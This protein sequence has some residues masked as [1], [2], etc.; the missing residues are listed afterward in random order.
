[1]ALCKTI[2]AENGLEAPDAYHRVTEVQLV[3]KQHMTF[4]QVSHLGPPQEVPG[5]RGPDGVRVDRHRVEDEQSDELTDQ[6]LVSADWLDGEVFDTLE[7]AN[8]RANA[9]RLEG[10]PEPDPVLQ[11]QPVVAM[12]RHFCGYVMDGPNP[13]C[14]AYEYLKAGPLEGAT[15]C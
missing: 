8:D 4:V 7:E 14:Q 3:D 6:Y 13:L 10:P 12:E 11:E 9:L 2:T 5:E 15:D 1:M